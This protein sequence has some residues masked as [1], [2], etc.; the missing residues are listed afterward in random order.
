MAILEGDPNQSVVKYI[1]ILFIAFV[2]IAVITNFIDYHDSKIRNE[3]KKE[4]TNK[5]KEKQ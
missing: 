4:L 2:L 1:V 3:I 5:P